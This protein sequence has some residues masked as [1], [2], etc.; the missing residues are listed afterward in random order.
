MKRKLICSSKINQLGWYPEFS[1]Q[2]GI[3]QLIITT[4]KYAEVIMKSGLKL[5][6]SSWDEKK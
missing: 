2:M 6:S 5:A 1:L 3:L 4:L